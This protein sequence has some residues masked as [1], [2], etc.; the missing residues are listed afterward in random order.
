[1]PHFEIHA[2]DVEAAKA[3]YAGLFGW[4]FGL[5][6]GAEEL[7]YHLIE[8]DQIGDEHPLTGGIMRRM[9]PSSGSVS[10][11]SAKR[12]W[13]TKSLCG[14]TTLKWTSQLNTTTAI[15]TQV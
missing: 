11:C 15:M 2:A 4:S 9:G 6:P 13:R 5:M 7:E 10:R 1:M 14:L 3:F 12:S 8:G